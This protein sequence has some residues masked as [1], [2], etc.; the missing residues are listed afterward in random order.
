MPLGHRP[1]LPTPAKA[2]FAKKRHLPLVP[3]FVGHLDGV[4]EPSVSVLL[5]SPLVSEPALGSAGN[6]DMERQIFLMLWLVS[7]F[8]SSFFSLSYIYQAKQTI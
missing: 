3:A 8:S 7:G 6:L 5:P 4:E 2:C 1:V